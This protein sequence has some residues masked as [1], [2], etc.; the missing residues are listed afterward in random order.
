[1]IFVLYMSSSR[2]DRPYCMYTSSISIAPCISMLDLPHKTVPRLQH[3]TIHPSS[4]LHQSP[5][6]SNHPKYLK[7]SQI[8]SNLLQ[9]PMPP[10]LHIPNHLP[11]ILTHM[12]KPPA[13]SSIKSMRIIA[14]S[15]QGR[16]TTTHGCLSDIVETVIDMLVHYRCVQWWCFTACECVEGGHYHVLLRG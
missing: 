10:P 1:M 6:H 7:S 3:V 12:R 8:L 16:I 5:L 15:L 14:L 11:I 13:I 4:Q 9:I 2:H